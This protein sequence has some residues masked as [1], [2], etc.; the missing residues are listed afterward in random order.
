MRSQEFSSQTNLR[1]RNDRVDHP[2]D[3]ANTPS[4]EENSR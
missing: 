4:A 1:T 3:S 2:T